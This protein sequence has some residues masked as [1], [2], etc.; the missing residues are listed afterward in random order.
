[1]VRDFQNTVLAK[2]PQIP[3][4]GRLTLFLDNWKKIT[5]DQWV[6]SVIKEG[7][8]LEFL[9]IPLPTGIRP[10]VVPVLD[11]ELI[12]Q[13]IDSLLQKDCIE[14]V[15][16]QNALDG[17]YST[18]FLVPK[19]NGTMR[20]VINLRPLNRY[21][22]K[23]HFKMDTLS[24]VINLLIPKDSA[25]TID[26]SDAY[27]HI[28]I[29]HGHRKYLG[30]CFKN[31]CYQWKVMCFGPTSAPRVF[32][33][34]VSVVAAY[35]RIQNVRLAVY[36]DGWLNLNQNKCSLLQDRE[37]C[38]NLLVSLGFMINLKKS[39]LYPS[40]NLIHLGALLILR[41]GLVL[42]TEERFVKIQLAL[43]PLCHLTVKARDFLH[44]LGLMASCIE[45]VPNA[46]LY[47]RPIQLHLV[48]LDTSQRP[49]G[50]VSSLYSSSQISSELVETESKHF[51]G[52]LC[53]KNDDRSNNHNRCFKTYVRGSFGQPVCTRQMEYTAT[54]LA[55]QSF[56]NGGHFFDN[57]TFLTP[58]KREICFNQIGQH[59][60]CSVYQSPG[61][62][63]IQQTVHENMGDME[64]C[65]S[66]SNDF[67][68]SPYL[69]QRHCISMSHQKV[70]ATEWSLKKEIV[71]NIFAIWGHP[72]MDLFASERNH[73][74][75]LFC[76]WFPSHRAFATDALSITWENMFAYAYP[77]ICLIP[78]VLKHMSQFQCEI[79]LIA[80]RWPCRHWYTEL[81]QFLIAS[82]IQ[83]SQ[84][85]DLL[86]QP[87]S[88]NL[89]PEPSKLSSSGMETVNR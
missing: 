22:A 7:Y 13:E 20:P 3:V 42:P 85:P 15:K 89:S 61:R 70:L 38:L 74:S 44:L 58:D 48:F 18:F 24:K 82:P 5:S 76:T 30:F 65:N 53:S 88:K 37:L 31:Q 83:L 54:K 79:I 66:E 29:F 34:L 50:K 2:L 64:S 73:Q 59:D 10:T 47:M 78:K 33:K 39:N 27:L 51:Q 11:Q 12:S 49:N 81:L 41:R 62:Y 84:I 77:P 23:K 86:A 1:M 60:L 52:S 46:R 80:P 17:F 45:L 71:Q 35:L 32:T 68:S 4:G 21:L 26:L 63:S 16:A 36:L 43:I 6:L 69:R 55:Y 14:K 56:G 87:F 9:S 40:Q 8:K 75:E 67:E 25:I 72:L 57:D 28:P 19:K